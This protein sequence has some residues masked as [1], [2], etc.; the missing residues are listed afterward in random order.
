[1]SETFACP[2]CGKTYPH[3]GRKPGKAVVC[4]CGHR[5]LVPAPE[6]RAPRAELPLHPPSDPR[7]ATRPEPKATPRNPAARTHL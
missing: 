7:P 6:V 4:T 5:F 1:M 3:A 2:Q